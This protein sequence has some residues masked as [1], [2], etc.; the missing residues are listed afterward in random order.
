MPGKAE[1]IKAHI[2]TRVR[3]FVALEE[4]EVQTAVTDNF[5]LRLQDGN[6]ATQWVFM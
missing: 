2:C 5:V 1:L 6:R 3:S 4:E